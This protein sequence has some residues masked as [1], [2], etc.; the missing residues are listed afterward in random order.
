MHKVLIITYYWPPSGG[1]GVQRWLKFVKYLRD[2]GWEPVIYTPSN[3]EFPVIDDTLAKDIPADIKV[4]KTPI[5]EPYEFY[6]KITGKK[7]TSKI[8]SGF[9]NDKKSPGLVEQLSVWIRGN[10]FIPDARKF[11]IKPSVR[12]LINY[13]KENHVDAIV[14]T[15]P[16]HSMHLIALAIKERLNIPWLA[17]FRDPWTD[18]D[19]YKDL[20]ISAFADKKHKNL[21]LKTIRGCSAMVVVSSDMKENYEK[22]GGNNVHLI[23]NG[24]DPDDMEAHEVV[25]D[26]KF[27]ISHIGTLPPSL[28]LKVLWQALSELSESVP[29]FRNNL[30][31]KLVGKVDKLVTDDLKALNLGEQLTLIE[32]VSHDKVASLMKQSAILLLVINK[33]SPNAKGI[34]TGKFFEYLASGR[35]IMAIGPTDGDLARILKESEAGVIAAYDNLEQIKKIVI[36]MYEKYLCSDLNNNPK[37]IGKYA[38]KNLT[39]ELAAILNKMIIKK[40]GIPD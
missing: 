8:N 22:M 29:N 25:R 24:F 31:I 4:I 33:D 34:L 15:G 6:K 19:Y 20:K 5:W 30:E 39:S 7:S 26:A 37:G 35:P 16:P 9:L 12:F 27:S 28:N 36:I 1:A 18:I 3:P 23:T 14:S 40:N 2:F 17:D 10:I 11:W 21:E 38:R 32:Y 13:L